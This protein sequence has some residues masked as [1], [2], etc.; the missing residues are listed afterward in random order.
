MES[1]FE[2]YDYAKFDIVV[3][4]V[5]VF[6]GF[7]DR[8]IN[9]ICR[10]LFEYGDDYMPSE[11]SYRCHQHATN[12]AQGTTRAYFSLKNRRHHKIAIDILNQHAS[13]RKF[14]DR[15]LAFDRGHR[16][17]GINI[18]KLLKKIK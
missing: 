17:S 5:P 11:K 16:E 18:K 3:H 12:C 14:H 9:A 7:R 1:A 4:N 10:V 2:F 15:W 8:L 6:P 13:E